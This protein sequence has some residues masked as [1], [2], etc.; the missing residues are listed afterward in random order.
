[1]GDRNLFTA[2]DFAARKYS[3]KPLTEYGAIS[4]QN[5]LLSN[6][7][8]ITKHLRYFFATFNLSNM[9]EPSK[10]N[11]KCSHLTEKGC[12]LNS[13][14]RPIHCIIFTCAK[15]RKNLPLNDLILIAGLTKEIQSIQYNVFK[16]YSKKSWFK[17]KM[18]CLLCI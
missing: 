4:T 16:V 3:N 7:H 5:E 10:T 11:V 12:N 1:M 17:V 15:F 8:A 14:D 9:N 18:R 6:Y 2:I 13:G